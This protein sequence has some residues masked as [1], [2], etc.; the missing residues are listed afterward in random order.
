[1]VTDRC[2]I[3]AEAGVN[4]NGSDALATRLIE[5]ARACGADAVKFQS[6]SAEKLVRPGAGTAEY[7]RAQTGQS[8]QLAMLKALEL[9]P[10]AFGRLKKCADRL[11][12]EF[13]STPFDPASARML[14]EIGMRK[15][16]V[17]SGE[18][19][20]LPFLEELAAYDLP[21][22]VSTGM[23]DLDE[24]GEAVSAV[25]RVRSARRLRAPLSER[26]A[27]LHCTSN[28]P[29]RAED[30]NLRAMATLRERFAVPV[31]YSDHSD[32]TAAAVAAV[33][34]GAAVIEKHF[35]LDRSLPGPDHKA[36]LAGEE[37]RRMIED[38]RAVEKG[39]GDGVKAPRSAELPVRD[40]V[41]RSVTLVRALRAGERIA[42][43]DVT[44][45]RPGGGIPPKDLGRVAGMRAVRD[46]AAGSTLT[47]ADLTC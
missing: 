32:G 28:Y 47:W 21:L 8:D 11:G 45:L 9:P 34:L 14:V 39:L 42:A 25:Q 46:L 41:R 12:I 1:V 2:F 20:N 29:A 31:G 7:Q 23:A 3:I 44:L 5:L 36:S 37:L 38:I 10:S 6:F 19:T 26:L 24:V 27:L 35:T 16:K 17:P 43:A 18:I 13:M 40:V 30:L 22:I 15:I 33:A 4:H